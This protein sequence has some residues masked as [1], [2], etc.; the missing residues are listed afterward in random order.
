MFVV[1]WHREGGPTEGGLLAARSMHWAVLG[2][3]CDALRMICRHL[4]VVVVAIFLE[5]RSLYF[6][7]G[8]PPLF[9]FDCCIF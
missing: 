5:E 1:I 6:F 8:A 7:L 2:A 9:T 3:M 4:C